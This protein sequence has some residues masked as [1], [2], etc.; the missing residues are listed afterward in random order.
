MHGQVPG[1][2]PRELSCHVPLPPVSRHND[3]DTTLYSFSMREVVRRKTKL[4]APNYLRAHN[5]NCPGNV[6]LQK[7]GCP[8]GL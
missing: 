6:A 2:F 5:L 3:R 7:S 4:T 8:K 1:V